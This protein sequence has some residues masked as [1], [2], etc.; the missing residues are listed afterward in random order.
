MKYKLIA[1]DLDGTFLD[2]EKHLIE[3]NV[4]ALQRACKKGLY[5]VPA[6]GRTWPGIPEQLRALPFIR[7]CITVN[8]AQIYDRQQD[9]ILHREEIPA[10]RALELMEFM[11]GVD[12]L[13]DC[14]QDNAGWMSRRFYE[15][16]EEYVTDP[17]LLPHVRRLRQPVEELKDM[18]RQNGRSVQK[19]Q[20]HFR[21]MELRR[22]YLDLLPGL[23]PDMAVTSSLYNN[24]EINCLEANKGAALE[25]LCG[26]LGVER[27]KS[28]A[29][30]DDTND[31]SML[32]AAGM[33]VAMGNA[34]DIVKA[35]A[36]M[37]TLTNDEAGLAK[38]L[39]TLLAEE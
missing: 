27:E 5:V 24:I 38:A 35:A 23:L 17:V 37:V 15:R 18:I 8:G 10:K 9:R 11:D 31:M 29:F 1:F 6:T 4:Q 21:D 30:G 39:E 25:R 20:M 13:Y 3:E 7:Y 34:K 12:A 16:L 33:G 14:Y 19:M 22:K 32:R 36:D 28:I 2:S 26:I